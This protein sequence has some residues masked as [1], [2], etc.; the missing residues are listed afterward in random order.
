MMTTAATKEAP[1]WG[2][3]NGDAEA[4]NRGQ[5]QSATSTNGARIANLDGPVQTTLYDHNRMVVEWGDQFD[6]KY[7]RTVKVIGFMTDRE[8]HECFFKVSTLRH[9]YRTRWRADISR[10]TLF[11]HLSDLKDAGV[12]TVKPRYWPNG[13]QRESLYQV[14]FGVVIRGGITAAAD[15]PADLGGQNE[16][17]PTLADLLAEDKPPTAAELKLHPNSTYD[18]DRESAAW[19]AKANGRR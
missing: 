5:I 10:A 9:K 14:H 6:R 1:A 16:D 7:R 8:S 18:L 4:Y 13:Q 19:W 11:R 15:Y 2:A 12:I 3:S 17:W